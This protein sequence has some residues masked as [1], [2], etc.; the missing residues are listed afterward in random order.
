[1][2]RAIAAAYLLAGDEDICEGVAEAQDHGVRVTLLGVPGVNQ[3]RLL[4]Q[5]SD[6]HRVMPD[7]FWRAHFRLLEPARDRPAAAALARETAAV[8]PEPQPPRAEYNGAMRAAFEAAAQSGTGADSVRA[9]LR[10]TSA[11]VDSFE[12]MA[13]EAGHD[14]ARELLAEATP[15]DVDRLLKLTGWQVPR[16]LDARLLRFAEQ[17]LGYLWERPELKPLVRNAFWREFRSR[18]ARPQAG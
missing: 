10:Q 16:D 8:E 5:Q 6:G 18:A 15:V 9:L 4:V 2:D 3:S 17:R 14:F 1:R 7:E 13:T 12:R 11:E